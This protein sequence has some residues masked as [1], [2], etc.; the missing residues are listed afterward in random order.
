MS[1]ILGLKLVL[2]PTLIGAVTL[3]GVRWGPGIAGWLSGFPIVLGPILFFIALDQGPEFGS[4]AALGTL[5]GIPGL[6][7][8]NAAYAQAATKTSWPLSLLYALLSYGATVYLMIL[9]SPPLWFRVVLAIVVLS[10]GSRLF[11]QLPA[12]RTPVGQSTPRLEI[13]FRML[14]AAGLV[15]VVTYFAANLGPQLSGVLAVFPLISIVLA[16]FSHHYSGAGFVT[17]LLK[18]VIFGWYA[19]VVFC[20]LLYLLLPRG[21]VAVA[22]TAAVG[23]AVLVQFGSRLLLKR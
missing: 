9:L 8:F 13:V 11:P 5:L 2:V 15:L 20:L 1:L 14:A 12:T 16:P 4:T 19:L 10:F 18:G 6:L 23:G 3:A 21:G 17:H 7:A 22:F